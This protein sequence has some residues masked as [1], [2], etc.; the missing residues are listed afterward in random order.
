M[1]RVATRSEAET[2]GTAEDA[3]LA[4]SPASGVLTIPP[5]YVGAR[6]GADRGARDYA[7][8]IRFALLG[9]EAREED[10]SSAS[11][12]RDGERMPTPTA[13]R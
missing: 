12:G 4:L 10:P 7:A 6:T 11:G 8:R 5:T 1:T 9:S 2:A 3:E 13:R